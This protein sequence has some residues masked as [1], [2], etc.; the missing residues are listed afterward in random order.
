MWT[1][2]ALND[3]VELAHDRRRVRRQVEDRPC[4]R[5]AR[6]AARLLAERH[7]LD[8]RRPGQRREHD[9]A[10]LGHG[11]RR[12]GPAW[13]RPCTWGAAASRR[14]SWTTSSWPAFCRLAAMWRPMVPSPMNPT[15]MTSLRRRPCVAMRPARHGRR[16][17]RVEGQVGDDLAD[18]LAGDA[19]G[20][21]ALEVPGELVAPVHGDQRG[22]G[23][24]AAVALGQPGPLPDVAVHDLLGQLDQLGRD[25]P[26]LVTGGRCGFRC[27]HAWLL[28]GTVC[29]GTVC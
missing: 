25:R 16:P 18:L 11:A 12:V 27:A 8:L 1:P 3:R 26:D 10:G 15:F 14:T 22:D 29:E 13:P 20:E 21:R 7:R 5:R 9:L 2:R 17:A 4:R 24:E 23:D 19:V 28:S 6:R